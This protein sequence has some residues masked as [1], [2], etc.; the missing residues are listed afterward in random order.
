[1]AIQSTYRLVKHA[2][3]Y[4]DA[5]KKHGGGHDLDTWDVTAPKQPKASE[6]LAGA[7]FHHGY[8]D[9]AGAQHWVFYRRAPMS[10]EACEK[11]E[12]RS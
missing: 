3:H 2:A 4:G 7:E 9:A 8:L 10:V 1:M 5:T 6:M 11:C 12:V